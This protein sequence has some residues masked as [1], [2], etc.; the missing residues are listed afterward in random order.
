MGSIFGGEKVK[1]CQDF[2]HTQGTTCHVKS[3]GKL[4]NLSTMQPIFITVYIL[5]KLIGWKELLELLT[6]F[7]CFCDSHSAAVHFEKHL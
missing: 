6:C 3:G 2:K 5:V 7:A 1:R 4:C